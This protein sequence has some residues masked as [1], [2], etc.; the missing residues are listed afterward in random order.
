M[1]LLKFSFLCS[2][3]LFC[4]HITVGIVPFILL[5]LKDIFQ[6]C[7]PP[8]SGWKDGWDGHVCA[9]GEAVAT[10]GRG[11]FSCERRWQASYLLFTGGTSPQPGGSHSG[12]LTSF[13]PSCFLLSA[14]QNSTRVLIAAEGFLWGSLHPG[15]QEYGLRENLPRGRK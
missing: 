6:S 1:E 7:S 4:A 2:E 14:S 8:L 5:D 13:L 10:A 9:M 12:F 3:S 11:W 15:S